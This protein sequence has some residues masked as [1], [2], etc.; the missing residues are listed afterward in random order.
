MTAPRDTLIAEL[1]EALRELVPAP[2]MAADHFGDA[3][4]M[5]PSP[6][7]VDRDS[8]DAVLDADFESCRR[9]P[10]FEG[11]QGQH[12]LR[13]ACRVRVVIDDE[14][15]YADAHISEWLPQFRER[16]ADPALRVSLTVDG[17]EDGEG[18]S[19]GRQFV[20]WMADECARSLAAAQ[21]MHG[22]AR[23][24]VEPYEAALARS[25]EENKRLRA[26][27]ERITVEDVHA[28]PIGCGLARHVE[29]PGAAIARAAL[30]ASTSEGR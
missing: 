30:N 3:H 7:P 17:P 24:L 8:R 27:L 4:N 10:Y 6:P 28:D 5:V 25:E 16:L 26:A 1:T 21:W 14:D 19:Y 13:G 29:Y 9:Y 22:A 18:T 23:K 20:Q 12:V 11:N 2:E 15:G